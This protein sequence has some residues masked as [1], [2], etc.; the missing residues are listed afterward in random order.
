MQTLT[1]Y[2]KRLKT[3]S[4]GEIAWRVKSALR[5]VGDRYRFAVGAYPSFNGNGARSE[6][7]GGC[8]PGFQ[9]SDLESGEWN[10]SEASVEEQ[11]WRDRLVRRADLIA[12]HRLS[13]LNLT[14]CHLGDPID[15]NR[16]HRSGKRAPM[17]FAPS[18]DYRDFSVTG[19][20][21]LVWEP[22]RHHHLVVLARAYRATG[23]SKYASAVVEQLESWLAQCPFGR[24]MNWRSPLELAIRVINWV[25]AM[26]LVADSPVV[27]SVF[28]AS[29]RRA[30][31]LHLWEIA[32]K[33]SQG[34]SANNHVIGEAAGVFMGAAYFNDLPDAARLR[35]QS[36]A[37]LVRE[38]GHQTYA[39]GCGREHAFGYQVF[40]MQFFLLSG[41][42]GRWT[43]QE[44][45]AEYWTRLERMLEFAGALTE[46]GGSPP[47]FGDSDDGYVLDLGAGGADLGGWL[48]IGA[49]V[50][51][52]SDLK[53]WAGG[54]RE[55]VRWLLGRESRA[56]F[57]AIE[58]PMSGAPIR[59][60]AFADSGYYLIQSGRADSVD[61]ISVFVDCAELGFRSIAAHGH[62]DALSFTLRAFGVDVL[63]D[64]GTYDY[65][66]HREWREYFRSTRAHNTLVIDDADQSVPLG[67]FMWGV[68]A[69]SRCLRW[70]P[71]TQGGFLV[72]EHDGYTRLKDPVVHRRSIALDGAARTVTIRDEIV[73]SGSHRAALYFHLSDACT[74]KAVAARR[75]HIEVAGGSLAIEIDPKMQFDMLTGSE[76]PIGGWVSHGYHQKVPTTTIVGRGDVFGTT[77]VEC[78]IVIGPPPSSTDGA[79]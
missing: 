76:H 75:C 53:A 46:G 26:D 22:N 72:A 13:F 66:S 18:I 59:S 28:R 63:V 2:V 35:E 43:G 19:D 12:G 17:D 20:C 40:V 16:D 11:A 78:R 7:P 30:V 61:R 15:W 38:I 58:S 50:F 1:W 77:T 29:V 24:G 56:R 32:R 33:Y 47:M 14:D 44:F 23:D 3:M 4:P 36:L 62:A 68:R 27:T 31:G 21:K 60:R 70:E 64:P 49:L 71:T 25:W 37:I 65:F 34:S 41:L 54:Y 42:V 69:R 45:P 51:D 6:V 8:V 48:A 57:E 39:D 5:E 9:V 74:V 73:A 52:R 79:A 55:P 10:T 67:L